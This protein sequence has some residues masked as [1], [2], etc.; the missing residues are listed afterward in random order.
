[1]SAPST[2][3]TKRIRPNIPAATFRPGIGRLYDE[4]DDPESNPEAALDRWS[5]V[6]G[7]SKAT[8]RPHIGEVYEELEKS[9]ELRVDS[10]D[11]R[12]R[13]E[14]INGGPEDEA[15]DQSFFRA[16]VSSVKTWANKQF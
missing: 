12:V 11:S 1:M 7:E 16:L 8:F 9:G 13:W 5:K 6:G 10:L 4:R 14:Q 15:V 3:A 2:R